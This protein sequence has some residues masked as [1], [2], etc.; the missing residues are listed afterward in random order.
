MGIMFITI[1]VPLLRRKPK[2]KWLVSDFYIAAIIYFAFLIREP[3]LI[4]HYSIKLFG[5]AR[6]G[7]EF[8]RGILEGILTGNVKVANWTSLEGIILNT[9]LFIPFGYLLPL[10]WSKA[11][12]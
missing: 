9:L 7:L 1:S 2:T 10:L 4:Y 3:T 8:G 6:K 12:R 5:A 11:D